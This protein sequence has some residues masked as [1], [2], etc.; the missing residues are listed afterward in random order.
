MYV[1]CLLCLLFVLP[2]HMRALVVAVIQFGYASL[3]VVSF[4]LAPLL[5]LINNYFEIRVD[6]FKL[7]HNTARPVPRKAQDIGACQAACLCGP[8]SAVHART[9][10]CIDWLMDWFRRVPTF[11]T[12]GS[13]C[14]A[15][16]QRPGL[17]RGR[18]SFLR[19]LRSH[20]TLN[21]VF[22]NGS[23]T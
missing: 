21:I 20:K 23:K 2:L 4:P 13:V 14:C 5:A 22:F 1:G 19:T 6:S 10:V 8:V 3:F 17:P 16:A 7:L 15:C 12:Y 9:P 18:Q 11:C